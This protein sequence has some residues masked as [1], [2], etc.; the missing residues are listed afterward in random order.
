MTKKHNA[1]TGLEL[2][3]ACGADCDLLLAWNNDV[4]AGG[5]ALSGTAPI[6]HVEH[7]AWLAGRLS[8]PNCHIWLIEFG[9]VPVGMIRLERETRK[10]IEETVVSIFVVQHARRLGLASTAIEWALRMTAWK[11]G[12][13]TAV[14]RV[15][16][17]NV[18]SQR[19]FESLDFIPVER[20]VDHVVLRRR[21]PA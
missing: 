1:Q 14:A 4:R 6:E 19:L 3:P 13:L 21:I 5:F 16:L 8:D 11:R 10:M 7:E 15:R 20:Q 9:G 12:T 18:A 17:G 2:R